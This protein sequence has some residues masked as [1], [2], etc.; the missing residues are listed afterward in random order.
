V[1]AA[2][3]RYVDLA[4]TQAHLSPVTTV[5]IDETACRGPLTHGLDPRGDHDY[6]TIA[7][8]ADERKVVF[9]TEGRDARTIARFAEHVATHKARPSADHH[10]EH[11]YVAGLH[12]GRPPAPSA[13][14][15][16]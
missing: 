16:R 11:R 9:V 1:H 7:A 8:D 2:C 14:H 3:S 4:V 5:A 15:L 6:L 13:R 10:S 12:P